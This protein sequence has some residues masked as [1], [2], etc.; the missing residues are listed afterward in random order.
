M[1]KAIWLFKTATVLVFLASVASA[2]DL[3][4]YTF[5][6]LASDVVDSFGGLVADIFSNW[7]LLVI[8]VA[9]IVI[10]LAVV[11]IAVMLSLGWAS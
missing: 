1:K 8:A 10:F 3:E 2:L 4:S 6:D 5:G 7:F 11:G 9:L